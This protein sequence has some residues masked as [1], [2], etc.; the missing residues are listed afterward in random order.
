MSHP[1]PRTARM[2]AVLVTAAATAVSLV[3]AAGTA[4]AVGGSAAKEGTHSYVGQLN[5]GDEA[6][7]RACSGVLVDASWVLTAASCF[8][9]TPGGAVPAGKPALK[10]TATFGKT[11]VDVIDLVPRGDRDL[12]MAKL[13][14]PVTDVPAAKLATAAS[15]KGADLT[16]LGFGRTKTEWVPGKLHTGS[17]TSESVSAVAQPMSSKA[18][19]TDTVCQGDTGGPVL[20][21]K[22]E[23]TAVSSRSWQGGCLGTDPAETRTNAIATRADGL[24]SWVRTTVERTLIKSG[25]V[26]TSGST[27]VGD[28]LK[29]TM[30]ADGNMVMYHNSGGEGKGASLWASGTYGNAGAFAVMQ[31]DGNLVIYKKGATGTDP[32]GALWNTNTYSAGAYLHLQDDGNL[33]MYKKDSTGQ[34]NDALW[35]TDTWQ[36]PNKVQGGEQLL[37]GSWSQGA[38]KLLLMAGSGHLVV[39]DM[40]AGKELWTSGTWS[41]GAFARMQTDGNLVIYKKDGGEGKGGALWNTNT[42]SAGAY[43]HFQDDGNLVVYK[44]DSTGQWNDALWQSGTWQ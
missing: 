17:F 11:V 21:G 8:A 20:N 34:W 14:R 28:H 35:S 3:S 12:V 32:S 29:L 7:S 38:T 1:R 37:P 30:Q 22:G 19:T 6:S 24:G 33:V 13:A 18:G 15:A 27:L 2:S 26:I 41:P 42:Y 31:A 44:K 39:W 4:H 10:G 43:L 36:R 23:V 5:I 25:Q 9:Q 16:V 40:V